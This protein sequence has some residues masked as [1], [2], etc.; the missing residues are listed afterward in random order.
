[1]D[2]NKPGGL[3]K[4]ETN[5]RWQLNYDSVLAHLEAQIAFLYEYQSM[6]GLM[7]KELPPKEPGMQGWRLSPMAAMSGDIDGKRMAKSAGKIFDAIAQ[8]NANTPWSVLAKRERTIAL[9]LA[10]KSFK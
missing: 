10:W 1:M 8:Q 7:R 2:D 6:L 5:K 9:G 3:R 4:E